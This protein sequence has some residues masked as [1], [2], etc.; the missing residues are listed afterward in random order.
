MYL[1]YVEAVITNSLVVY[2]YDEKHF[3][4]AQRYDRRK[5]GSKA[6]HKE[7]TRAKKEGYDPITASEMAT[8]MAEVAAGFQ[9]FG[10]HPKRG[11]QAFLV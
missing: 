9:G 4:A 8:A 3:T 7:F 10:G 5:Q 2:L 11:C 1:F 6:C